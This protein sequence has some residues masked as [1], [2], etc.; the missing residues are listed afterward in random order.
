MSGFEKRSHFG[1]DL[2]FE[3]LICTETR[4]NQLSFIACFM[5]VA[6]WIHFLCA[7]IQTILANCETEKI[8]F[9]RLNY[10]ELVFMV[11]NFCLRAQV[12]GS[13]VWYPNL[14]KR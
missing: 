1:P 4:G 3:I 10:A 12:E 5:F 2:N 11:A 13:I 9:S 6:A 8:N 7:F 14:V